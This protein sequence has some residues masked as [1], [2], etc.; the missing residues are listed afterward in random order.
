MKN[1]IRTK[2][3]NGLF[4]ILH[5]YFNDLLVAK[6]SPLMEPYA[7]A[8]AHDVSLAFLEHQGILHCAICGARFGLHRVDVEHKSARS[9][10][11]HMDQVSKRLHEVV[12]AE[13]EA[14]EQAKRE[15]EAH[16]QSVPQAVP[17]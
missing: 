11:T 6:L 7:Q 12:K 3:F 13:K 5:R 4:Y 1:A 8:R 15:R 14:A 10:V 16:A 9:C 17:A 2:L